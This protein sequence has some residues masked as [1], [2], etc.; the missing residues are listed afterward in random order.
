MN[1]IGMFQDRYIYS[2]IIVLNFFYVDSVTAE[3][4][5][6]LSRETYFSEVFI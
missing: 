2:C 1:G 5:T 6:N 4:I 3:T